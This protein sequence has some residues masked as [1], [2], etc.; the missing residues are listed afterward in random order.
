MDIANGWVNIEDVSIEHEFLI[1]DLLGVKDR[2]NIFIQGLDSDTVEFLNSFVK[3]N[4]LLE[5]IDY[6]AFMNS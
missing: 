1:K 5:S 4:R 3:V 2:F 6:Q